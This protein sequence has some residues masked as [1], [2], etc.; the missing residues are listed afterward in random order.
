MRRIR[1]ALLLDGIQ[2]EASRA[3]QKGLWMI[4]RL[5]IDRKCGGPFSRSSDFEKIEAGN[6][7]RACRSLT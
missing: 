3:A 4:P 1:V 2:G 7:F 5:R 6:R